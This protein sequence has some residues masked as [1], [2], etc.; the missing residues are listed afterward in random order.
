MPGV[1]ERLFHLR[2]RGTTV[3]AELRGGAVTFATMSYII[4]VQ[5][6]VLS[7]AA[8][9]DFGAVMTATCVSAALATLVMGLWANYPIAEAPLMGENFFFAVSVVSL[10]KVPWTVALGIVFLS[11]VLFLGLTLLRVREMIL[12]AVPASLKAAIAAGIGIFIA[13]IG[14]TQAGIVAKSPAAGAYVQIGD[15][16]SPVALVALAGLAVT[17]VLFARGVRGGIL[18]GLAFTT[19][20]AIAAGL[21]RP[22]GVVALPPSLAPTLFKL[23]IGAAWRHVDLVLV[24][25][26][27]LVFDTVGTLIGVSEQA[28]LTVD[29]RLPRAGRAMLA[30][31]VG[32]LAGAALGTSTVSSYIESASGVV[33]GARTGLANVLT[34]GLFLAALFFAPV[35]AMV[36]GGVSVAGLYYYPITAPVV[37]LVGSLMMAQAGRIPW[38]DPTEAIPAFATLTLIP[39]TFNIAH[40]VAGGIIFYVLVK[41]GAGRRREISWLMWVLAA[42]LVAAYALLP[43]LRH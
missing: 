38:Q 24:F 18:I 4:F 27:M 15:L 20:L 22:S 6:A 32:T 34:A 7:Q 10:M 26:I 12:D 29:G 17:A 3:A 8:G 14:L 5:P 19:A 43:R 23:D 33:E 21:V 35:V 25:L 41:A 13:F 11:G 37:I 30:D 31:A 9:M 1:L 40:G 36:G 2:E 16:A 28:G 42:V 39:F